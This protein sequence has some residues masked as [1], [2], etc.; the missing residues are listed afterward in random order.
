MSFDL[1]EFVASFSSC[2]SHHRMSQ[3]IED[4]R[5]AMAFGEDPEMI[6]ADV[7]KIAALTAVLMTAP[8]WAFTIHSGF[9][10]VGELDSL[11]QWTDS[12]INS[13]PETETQWVNSL[14]SP[15]TIFTIKTEDVSY[16]EVDGGGAW[17]FALMS[18]PGY[19]IIKNANFWALFENEASMSWA[20]FNLDGLPSGMNLGGDGQ[21]TISHVS[22]FG[23]RQ[24]P[25]PGSIGLIA[26]GLF[27]LAVTRRCIRK[28]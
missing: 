19:Y 5:Y 9:T 6:G 7:K 14:L 3:R 2:N 4:A 26:A 8:S 22:E 23:G 24:I 12:L 25:E 15:D 20:V 10:D 27:G 16:Y 13:N 21:M 28:A 1:G 11:V 18:D 17:A